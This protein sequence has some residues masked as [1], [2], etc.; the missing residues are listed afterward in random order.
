M[1]VLR[2]ATF[3]LICFCVSDGLKA[4]DVHK[5]WLDYLEGDWKVI[6]GNNEGD[7]TF[8]RV[9]AVEAVVFKG[10]VG[11][12]EAAGVLGW[13]GNANMFVENIYFSDSRQLRE[14]T[15]V[16]SDALSGMMKNAAGKVIGKI[17]YRRVNDDTMK[18]VGTMD[19]GTVGTMELRRKRAE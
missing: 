13:H 4:E 10:M 5:K 6:L 8:M 1:S 19:D 15:K 3:A 12:I 9:G 17:E 16:T 11:K 7:A 14:F 2:V 18:L